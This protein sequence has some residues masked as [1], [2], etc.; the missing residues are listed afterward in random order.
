[1]EVKLIKNFSLYTIGQFLSQILSLIMLPVYLKFLTVEDYGI[2]A[3]LMAIATFMNAIMQFGSGPTI[4]RYYYDYQGDK[5]GFKG[6]FT[7][8]LTFL[9]IANILI[10]ISV[11]IGQRAIFGFLIPHVNI[12]DYI[13][14][15]LFYS[16]FF[17]VPMLNLALFRVESKPINF[18]GFNVFQFLISFSFIY[19]LVVIMDK[20]ALG[21]IQ[22]E[23][24]ARI[25]MFVFGFYLFRKYLRINAISLRDIKKALKFGLPLLL[26]SLLWWALYKMDYFLIGNVLGNQGV[27]MFNVGFQISYVLITIGISF[28]LAWTPY[29]FSIATKEGTPIKYGNIICHF[30]VLLLF[31]GVIILLF[32]KQALLVLG[33]EDYL[34]ILTFLPALIFGAIFQA[35]YYM[36]QQLLMFVKKTIYIPI[37]LGIGLVLSFTGEYAG[38]LYFGL[39]GLSIAK[40]LG[41]IFVFIVT[42]WAGHKFYQIS[43]RK[44]RILYII[45]SM[46]ANVFLIS[47]LDLIQNNRYELKIALIAVN[48]LAIY[49]G[50]LT[51]SD[52]KELQLFL[53][54]IK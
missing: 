45:I 16:F 9:L 42:F 29:F 48:F 41:F 3:S 24:W 19:I 4:M 12:S 22:G 32:A 35:G 44:T 36:I 40:A 20:G 8:V 46:L 7:S 54:R 50:Y 2:V 23:F 31:A 25:P 47:T 11:L 27:G 53:N 43:V 34:P 13:Y 10:I 51:N 37:I 26:Q 5:E 14:Y 21:K 17:A 1:M 30:A 18:L 28:S 38:I 6:F 39:V 15:L 33:A 52:K 49:W